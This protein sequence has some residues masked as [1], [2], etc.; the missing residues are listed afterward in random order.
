MCSALSHCPSP[1]AHR[2]TWTQGGETF[3]D[4]SLANWAF[5]AVDPEPVF[6][7][8]VISSCPFLVSEEASN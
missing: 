5:S 1:I 8:F 6:V 3:A 2:R 7:R 4:R